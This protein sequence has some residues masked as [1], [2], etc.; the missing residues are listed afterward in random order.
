MSL[1]IKKKKENIASELR[2]AVKDTSGDV[3]NAVSLTGNR[4]QG[5]C[6]Q[7]SKATVRRVS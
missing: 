7:T 4:N 2:R 5:S 3:G 6:R 1:L